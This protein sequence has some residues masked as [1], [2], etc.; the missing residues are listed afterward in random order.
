MDFARL[1]GGGALQ[2]GELRGKHVALPHH[3]GQRGQAFPVP[4]RVAVSLRVSLAVCVLPWLF[5]P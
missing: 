4:A 3:V 5:S 2:G 1:G